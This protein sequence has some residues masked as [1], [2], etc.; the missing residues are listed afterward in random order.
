M[1]GLR[2]M[3][4]PYTVIL[5]LASGATESAGEPA[6]A[7]R[8][9]AGATLSWISLPP[10]S[11][12]DDT[13]HARGRGA[14][15]TLSGEE[16]WIHTGFRIVDVERYGSGRIPVLRHREGAIGA[17]IG[18][19]R[20]SVAYGIGAVYTRQTVFPLRL[21]G[22][23]PSLYLRIGHAEAANTEV[24]F[25]DPGTPSTSLGDLRLALRIPLGSKAFFSVGAIAELR[26]AIAN[27]L[28]IG[29]R[30]GDGSDFIFRLLLGYPDGRAGTGAAVTASGAGSC[31]WCGHLVR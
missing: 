3:A 9:T 16:T 22:T 29:I 15:A 1:T 12:T 25:A 14:F 13:P 28:G 2:S 31:D 26:P 17:T 20:G 30:A 5:L 7:N 8:F 24:S 21:M 27:E 18:V 4:F 6:G 11:G 23:I 19:E 10:A